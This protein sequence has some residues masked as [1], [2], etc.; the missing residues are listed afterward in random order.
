M[1]TQGMH[2]KLG[3]FK[4]KYK[5]ELFQSSRQSSLKLKIGFLD[6]PHLPNLKFFLSELS[7][8]LFSKDFNLLN[9]V[10]TFAIHR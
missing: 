2:G 8:N 4:H 6:P 3:S 9:F 10:K 7:L 1:R 5:H